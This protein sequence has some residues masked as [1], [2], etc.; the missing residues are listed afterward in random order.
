MDPIDGITQGLTIS[1]AISNAEAVDVVGLDDLDGLKATR[2]LLVGWLLTIKDYHKD[3]LVGTMKR[4]W[5]TQ[6]EFSSVTLED[7]KRILF[8]F[9]SDLDCKRVMRFSP[10]TISKAL[11]L[12][13]ATDG[14]VDPYNVLL[15]LQN[16]WVRVWGIPP[17]FLGNFFGDLCYDR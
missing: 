9:K 2:F 12:L 5:H 3:S 4:T 17:L 15:D 8:S 16:F 13:L 10:W 6:E 11:L 7:S 1:L 14:S